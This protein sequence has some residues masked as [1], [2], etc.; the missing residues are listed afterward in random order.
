MS[1][2]E[3]ISCALCGDIL[4]SQRLPHIPYTGFSELRDLLQKHECCFGNLESTYHHQEG[5][6]AAFPGGHYCMARPE[7][8]QDLRRIGFNL[9][10]TANN[11]AMDYESGGLLA[12]LRHLDAAGMQ[13]AGTGRNLAEAARASFFE[14]S[15]GRVAM[16]SVTSSFH[17]SYAAGPQNGELCG[18]PGVAPLRHK[19]V[20]ELE[21]SKFRAITEI[22]ESCHV[23]SYHNMGIKTGFLPEVTNTRF[24]CYE[25]VCG[26]ENKVHT[27]PNADDLK[28][29]TDIIKDA[30]YLADLIIV[31]VHSHQFAGDDTTMPPEF[32]Q[33]FC[34]AC[35]DAG[36]DIVVGTG[37]HI[38]R[39]IEV[40]GGGVIFHGLGNFIFQNDEF[41]YL[42]EEFYTRRKTSRAQ[43]TGV[44][45]IGDI[46]TQGWTR[47]LP[48]NPAA[49]ESVVVSLQCSEKEMRIALHPVNILFRGA[50]KGLKGLPVLA[51]NTAV[52]QHLQ[53]LS[54]PWGTELRIDEQACTAHLAVCRC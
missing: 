4:L 24:G 50:P 52:L 27:S 6:P 14:T 7:C 20:Y 39:G 46:M 18:R 36:A 44:G 11:H 43:V 31:S 30:H 21:E 48:A 3:T 12:T 35:I 23:N 22:A 45:A 42:P 41:D 47:G 38:L 51:D 37:P 33:S 2:S 1:S 19:A 10:S 26:T 5:W 53:Q 29:T 8:L 13:H 17:D 28:R 49:W 15:C 32:V 25:F 54:Q 34:R 40:Y 9:V 16:L